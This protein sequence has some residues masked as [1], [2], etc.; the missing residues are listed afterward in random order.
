MMAGITKYEGQLRARLKDSAQWPAFPDGAFLDR[1]DRTA[2][3]SM[4]RRTT[5]GYL[6]AIL[7]YHQLAEEML[8]LLIR[9]VQFLVQ[10]GVFPSRITFRERPKLTFG[11]LQQ[12]LKDS[13]EFEGRIA[14]L[15]RVDQLNAIRIGIVHKLTKRGSLKGLAREARRAERIYKAVFKIFDQTHDDFRV[16][17]HGYK[18]DVFELF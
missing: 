1:L 4:I 9:D 2:S 3:H 15:R 7:I 18:K 17:F 12:E 16:A 14:F 6:A 11:Q 5:E 8:R 13:V 10:L